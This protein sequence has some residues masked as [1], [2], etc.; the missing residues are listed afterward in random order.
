MHFEFPLFV[1]EEFAGKF[2]SVKFEIITISIRHVR[3]FPKWTREANLIIGMKRKSLHV[4]QTR[5]IQQLFELPTCW[6]AAEMIPLQMRNF[7]T[8]MFRETLALP[9]RPSLQSPPAIFY[10]MWWKWWNN[11]QT[12]ASSKHSHWSGILI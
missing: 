2:V 7:A 4:I 9:P 12:T 1:V 3:S 10:H 11:T 8:K 6:G 5:I